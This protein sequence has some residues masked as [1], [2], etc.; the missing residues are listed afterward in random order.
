VDDG[1]IRGRATELDDLNVSDVRLSA[2]VCQ[3]AVP[4]LVDCMIR[5]G[6]RHLRREEHQIC[7]LSV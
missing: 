2:S 5:G 7:A 4:R 3:H 6:G 1:V